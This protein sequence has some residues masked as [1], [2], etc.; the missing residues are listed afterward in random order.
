MS[1][2]DKRKLE[3]FTV[4]GIPLITSISE[5][6]GLRTIL[7]E[8]IAPYG[9]E[10]IPTV[11]TL[12]IL[13]CNI[14]IGRQPL[15]E[16]EQW[17]QRIDPNCHGLR[18]EM[19][20]SFNDDRFG[21]A[22]DKLYL[23]DRAS[24]MTE[25]VMKMIKTVDLDLSRIHN[26]STTVKAYGK[27]PGTT[28]TGLKLARGNSKE[29]RPDLKQLVFSL[30]ISSDGAV[31]VHYKT[32]P[33]NRTDD[34]T[35]IE[36]WN[37]VRRIAG[38]PEFIYVADCKVCTSKQLSYIVGEGGRIITIMPNTWKES[39]TFKEEL[40]LEKKNKKRILIRKVPGQITELEYFSLFSGDYRT[41]KAGYRIYWIHS[42]EKRKND[43][44]KREKRLQKAESE[45]LNLLPKLNKRKLKTKEEIESRI[46]SILKKHK[47]KGFYEMS[48]TEVTESYRVQIGRGR[49]GPNTKYKKCAD[50][51]FSFSWERDKESLR[52]EK[53]VDGIFPLLTT[54]KSLSAKEVLLAYKYQP[55]LE[56]RF[57]QF[58][59]VHEA[60]PLLFKKIERVE[61][62]MFLFFL[63]LMIQAIIEREVRL[64]MKERAIETL[65]IYPEFRDS[66]H[67]TTSK[68][69]DTFDG[70]SSYLVKLDKE[71]TEEFR[72][73]LT[74]TQEKIL[75]LLGICLNYYWGNSFETDNNSR[76]V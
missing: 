50:T 37:T 5:R 63:S 22:L 74:E 35:H 54:D 29:H 60:A 58:R 70:V 33:G 75:S 19:I 26:D 7:S 53:N 48:L 1:S 31:P 45:L 15:Y 66:Y 14:T 47:V 4:A 64:K 59:S 40:R 52:Q 17:V 12:L 20:D 25:I 49:P 67:P 30:T 8:Y 71:T 56:K 21:R 23:A 38:A 24:L 2:N 39:T 62:I 51:V 42:S 76:K 46:E 10:T 41:K 65:P 36:T 18:I 6:L 61:G 69:L 73:S 3:R 9:N 68:I 34:T 28:R 27:I 16:L 11:D 44:L 43:L 32:Y 55:R 13:M 57:T 72:D